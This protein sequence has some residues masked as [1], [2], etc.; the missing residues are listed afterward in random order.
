MTSIQQRLE[1]HIPQLISIWHG[2]SKQ[3]VLAKH[4]VDSVSKAL[5]ELQ[6]GLTGNRDLAGAGYMDNSALF[7]AYLLYYWPVSY[8]QI[9][10]AMADCKKATQSFSRV[11]RILDLGSGPGPASV[12]VIDSLLQNNNALTFEVTLVDSSSKALSV[13][14]KVIS[15]QEKVASVKTTVCD[16][17]KEA[18]EK[19]IASEE[20]FDIIVMS[21]A[22][23][24]LWK[25]ELVVGDE[26]SSS[27]IKKRML[28]LK[29]VLSHLT[30]EG[31]ALVCEPALLTTSRALIAVR[32]LLVD[33]GYTVF[34]PCPF[35]AMN[36]KTAPH[37]PALAAGPNHTCHVEIEWTPCEPI[38]S[39][40]KGAGLDRESVKMTYFAIQNVHASSVVTNSNKEQNILGRIVSE[41]MLN[42]AGRIRFL[43]CDGKRQIAISAKKDEPH[44]KQIG[45]FDLK[46]FD[47]VTVSNPEVRGDAKT[48]AYGIGSQT[49]I[50][51]VPFGNH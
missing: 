24:E 15:T 2:N 41:G 21:H 4:E 11:V 47:S 3:L 44:A 16:F 31:M 12:A 18:V 5:L 13:A 20:H 34:A 7:G 43:V 8:M 17:E 9:S 33:E 42:K 1:K 50:H 38:A 30:S 39:L 27:V 6:R 26:V 37:C 23:N 49:E 29:Q 48:V 40:A 19:M 28:F 32:D 46:R 45:F 10:Y 36:N 22:L 35:Y 14:Q 51:V 25:K